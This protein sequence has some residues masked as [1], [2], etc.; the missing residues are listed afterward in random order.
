MKS[1]NLGILLVSAL[2]SA[3]SSSSDG[4]LNYPGQ[5]DDPS[6]ENLSSEKAAG[7]SSSSI[8]VC[9]ENCEKACYRCSCSE[10][11]KIVLADSA[12]L[13]CE[14][15][16]ELSETLSWGYAFVD[17]FDKDQYFNP[18]VEYDSLVDARD[19]NVYKTVK[20]GDQVWMA[21]NLRFNGVVSDGK[22]IAG[23]QTSSDKIGS[24]YTYLSAMALYSD[25]ADLD[26]DLQMTLFWQG[27]CPNGWHI[28][29]DNEW[30]ALKEIAGG[31]DGLK[32]EV[33]W[34]HNGDNSTGFS[35]VP[36]HHLTQFATGTNP[37]RAVFYATDS[38][39][40]SKGLVAAGEA[41]FTVGEVDDPD[42][43]V[44]RQYY[45]CTF[46]NVKPSPC[47]FMAV[48]CVKDYD[49]KDGLC[50]DYAL[51]FPCKSLYDPPEGV[52]YDTLEDSRD[53]KTY[54]A[55]SI[56][57]QTWMAE[58]LNFETESG[59]FCYDDVAANCD[60]YGRLY[61]GSVSQDACPS[62]WHLPSAAEWDSLVSVAGGNSAAGS[63][64]K[65]RWGWNM[66]GTDLYGFSA[67]AS[68]RKFE[69]AALVGYAN[70]KY[71]G[72]AGDV[73]GYWGA[74][75]DTTENGQV[76]MPV[77]LLYTAYADSVARR[78][79]SPIAGYSIRCVKD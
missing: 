53:G 72:Y 17:D 28:P 59:S 57:D 47:Q 7:K 69:H 8:E 76:T 10:Q 3:C 54:R 40:C 49:C 51:D 5:G 9:K 52:V 35:A 18:D 56:G 55:V 25:F 33:G 23:G 37:D 36:Q 12:Y 13:V 31:W 67:V 77:V 78:R 16:Y 20:I 11:G 66:K 4:Q 22:G 32:S 68:G 65:S 14:P 79:D 74:D 42:E 64:L 75:Q 46:D 60:K 48:R 6:A 30:N 2:L 27:N 15:P 26:F 70:V 43:P 73:A 1:M 39:R 63:A 71:Y 38:R 58:N 21:E 29:N 44:S 61:Q 50:E 41:Y 34:K 45:A 19:G 62:G 24:T